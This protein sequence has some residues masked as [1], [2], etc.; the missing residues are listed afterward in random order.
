MVLPESIL[1]RCPVIC[2]DAD[3][4]ANL[5]YLGKTERQTP[6]YVNK[7]YLSADLK[8]V[9]GNIEPHQFMGF[10]GGVKSAA[11][12]LAG[13]ATI[14]HNHALMLEDGSQMGHYA[15][16]PARQDVEEIGALIGI[17]YAL[18]VVLN[19]QKHIVN[20]LAGDPVEV[21]W[22][23]IPQVRQIFEVAVDKPFDILIT[24]PGGHPKDINLYQ[25]QKA[26]AHAARVTKSGGT[27]ILVAACPEGTGSK[28][29]ESWVTQMESHQAVLEKFAQ[30]E[31]RLGRHKAFQI[32]RDA[33]NRRVL[34]VSEMSPEFV[35]RLLLTPVASLQDGLAQALTDLPPTTR[36][37][38]MPAANATIPVLKML[39]PNL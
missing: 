8:L 27:I 14:N 35:R 17:D 33:V 39:S 26:L 10:S 16:N 12:G 28:T 23:G 36:I 4:E 38:V 34:L 20:V 31:F 5:V 18:N 9:V 11:I 37:G 3:D 6:I 7:H 32:S 22:A 13:K 2:H 19:A 29:Y 25:A 15:D 24:S 1:I 21:M 30:D